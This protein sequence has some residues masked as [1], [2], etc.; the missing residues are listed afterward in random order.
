MVRV[1]VAGVERARDAGELERTEMDEE[2][3][4][5]VCLHVE[6]DHADYGSAI[7]TFSAGQC[8]RVGCEC[9]CF[10]AADAE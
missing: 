7:G 10:E 2:K 4:C 8:L 3:K 1:G 9:R 5:F 6:S